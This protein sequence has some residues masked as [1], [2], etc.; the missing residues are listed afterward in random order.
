MM[1]GFVLS[2]RIPA[3]IGSIPPT[4][5]GAPG[6]KPGA[7]GGGPTGA[8]PEGGPALG[9]AGAFGT[10]ATPPFSALIGVA[11]LLRLGIPTFIGGYSE[12]LDSRFTSA[13]QKKT[14]M[15]RSTANRGFLSAR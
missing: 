5:G 1:Y 4:M 13:I 8:G 11:I 15:N 2:Q 10:G 12:K 6:G 14:T 3:L 9:A 7:E